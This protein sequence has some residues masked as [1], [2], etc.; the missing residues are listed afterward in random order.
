[1]QRTENKARARVS[2]IFTSIE[3]EGYSLKENI[4]YPIIGLSFKMQ[5]V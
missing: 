2:E 5:M 4:V 1:M 3:G